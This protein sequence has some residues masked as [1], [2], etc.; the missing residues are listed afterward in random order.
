MVSLDDL[1]SFK[2]TAVL[3]GLLDGQV[4]DGRAPAGRAGDPLPS[5][6]TQQ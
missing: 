1:P 4:P 6:V 5:L 2:L 3:D